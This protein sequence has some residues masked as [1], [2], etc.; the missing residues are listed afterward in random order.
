MLPKFFAH[1]DSKHDNPSYAIMF[2]GVFSIVFAFGV[3]A[4]AGGFIDPSGGS[5]VYG[6][7]GFLTLGILP[8]YVLTN[9][10]AIRYFSKEPDFS[11]SSMPCFRPSRSA[12]G[13]F[14]LRAD[15][16]ADDRPLHLVP[17]VIIGW[18]ICWRWPHLARSHPAAPAHFGR[19][20]ARHR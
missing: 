4:F 7:L 2:Q 13:R 6:Y 8:V 9:I 5:N 20:G 16:P 10:A 19:R 14:A 1:I 18:V 17:L 12:D 11:V 15:R 3:G